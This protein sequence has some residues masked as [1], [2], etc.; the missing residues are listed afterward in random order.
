MNQSAMAAV[1]SALKLLPRMLFAIL[2]TYVFVVSGLLSSVISLLL[3]FLWPFAKTTYRRVTSGLAYTVLGREKSYNSITCC[4]LVFFPF[5]LCFI[6]ILILSLTFIE[7]VW[8]CV[9]YA[10]LR[11]HIFGEKEIYDT[12]GTESHLIVSSHRGDLDWVS[13]ISLGV[14]Y[15]FLHVRMCKHPVSSFLIVCHPWSTIHLGY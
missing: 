3:L 13:G 9:D 2:Y 4:V 12:L 11:I 6:K 1:W 14:Y 15:G 5:I 8:I 7:M 10:D